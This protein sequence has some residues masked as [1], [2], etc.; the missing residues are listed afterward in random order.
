MTRRQIIIV[1]CVVLVLM[2]GIAISRAS[3][4]SP[5]TSSADDV[6]IAAVKRGELDL[7]VYTTGEL[8]A[9]NSVTLSAPPVAGASLQITHL[10]H[11]GAAVKKGNVVKA[12]IVRQKKK[13]RRPDGSFIRFDENAA[14]LI[15]DEGEPRA[16]RIFGP[17]GRELRE[18]K[19]M[20]IVSL[21]PEV[22]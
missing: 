14:V 11:T 3:R 12:V 7:R 15:N 9:E 5:L 1:I 8:E 4:K 2:A 20:K 16:T 10:L 22:I 17:V 18:K 21:A 19:F 13:M 6:P